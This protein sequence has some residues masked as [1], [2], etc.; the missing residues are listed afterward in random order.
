VFI[1]Q[2]LFLRPVLPA[3]RGA[4]P[5]ALLPSMIVIGLASA[6]LVFSVLFLVVAIPR[7]FGAS[8]DYL[9]PVLP[10]WFG[11]VVGGALAASWAVFTVLLVRWSSRQTDPPQ[12]MLGRVATSLF[13]GTAVEALA[14]IPVDVMIRRRTSCYCGEASC[15]ALIL[16]LSGGILVAGPALFLVWTRRARARRARA[17]ASSP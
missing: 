4:R 2:L 9:D 17:V 15:G 7:L 5:R 11:W 12:D 13:R 14:L 6:L 1:L 8:E 10:D 16:W 3:K